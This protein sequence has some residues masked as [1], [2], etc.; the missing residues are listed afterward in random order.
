MTLAVYSEDPDQT[1]HLRQRHMQFCLTRF[2]SVCMIVIIHWVFWLIALKVTAYKDECSCVPYAR[3]FI[4]VQQCTV[5]D[6]FYTFAIH[7]CG[8]T[9][10]ILIQ[11]S[12]WQFMLAIYVIHVLHYLACWVK[13]LA[14]FILKYF[15]L[16]FIE[17]RIWHFMQ[18][19]NLHGE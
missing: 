1:A 17:N 16:I 5:H 7:A 6:T 13:I 11:N 8:F 14:D 15:F 3:G 19:D 2:S 10:A 12:S 9:F 4:S 18:G